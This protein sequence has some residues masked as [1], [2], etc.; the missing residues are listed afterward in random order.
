M[1]IRFA[2]SRSPQADTLV[3]AV[4]TGG[5]E[6]LP[7]AAGDMAGD[8]AGAAALARFAGECRAR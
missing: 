4:K 2:A 3:Y 1:D 5:L 8:M 6:L 7:A